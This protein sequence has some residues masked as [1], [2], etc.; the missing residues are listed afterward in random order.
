LIDER[1]GDV[2]ELVLEAESAAGGDFL[3]EEVVRVPE[4]Q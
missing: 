1:G 4:R 3:D 2:E